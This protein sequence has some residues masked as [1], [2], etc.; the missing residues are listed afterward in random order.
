MAGHAGAAGA[1]GTETASAA[2]KA[3][4]A[5]RKERMRAKKAAK[6]AER[7]AASDDEDLGASAAP[8]PQVGSMHLQPP[9]RPSWLVSEACMRAPPVSSWEQEL[10]VCSAQQ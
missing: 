2:G 3:G 6:R 9:P 7:G 10:P 8:N 5:S 4:K 1:E